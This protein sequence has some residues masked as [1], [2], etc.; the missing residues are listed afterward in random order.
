[1]SRAA[2]SVG[3]ARSGLGLVATDLAR[4]LMLA[5]VMPIAT[6]PSRAARRPRLPPETASRAAIASQSRDPFAAFER[7][8]IGSSREGVGVRPIASYAARSTAPSSLK[9]I[10]QGDA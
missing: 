1:M 9:A 3:S 2:K 8:R 7:R 6:T 10:D 5:E 4:R